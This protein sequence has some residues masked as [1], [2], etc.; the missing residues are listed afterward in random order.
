MPKEEIK[1]Y[2]GYDRGQVEV[3]LRHVSQTASGH[4]R[5]RA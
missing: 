2:I 4:E 5:G 3:G 1:F